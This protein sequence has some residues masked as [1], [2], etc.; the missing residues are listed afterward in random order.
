MNLLDLVIIVFILGA[1]RNGYR[2]GF[3][4]SSLSYVGLVAGT[5]LGAFVAP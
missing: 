3:S 4:L 1:L 5:A 2:R